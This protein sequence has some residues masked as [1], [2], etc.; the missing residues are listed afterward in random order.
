MQLLNRYFVPFALLLILSAVYF[1]EP[2]P[3]DYKLSLA[4]LGVST[5]INW[6]LS[7]NLYHFYQWAWQMRALQVVLSLVWTI[8]LFYLLQPYWAPMWLLFV[9][10]PAT[11]AMYWDRWK[12]LGMS[13]ISAGVMLGIY[14]HR[15]VEG[16]AMS[17]A[18]VQASFII[19]FSL[20]VHGL[21]ETALRLRDAGLPRA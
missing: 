6:W 14:H 2:D 16:M 8:P 3:R 11:A 17:M 18:L 12:T 4:I 5:V 20:F 13:I 9:M 1:S 7:K 15:G 10:A 21:V 19:V